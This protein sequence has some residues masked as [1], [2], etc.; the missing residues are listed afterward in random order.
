MP[1]TPVVIGIGMVGRIRTGLLGRERVGRCFSWPLERLAVPLPRVDELLAVIVPWCL[2]RDPDHV[3]RDAER[4][5][6]PR[7]SASVDRETLAPT[8]KRKLVVVVQG[9][10][11]RS[12]AQRLNALGVEQSTNHRECRDWIAVGICGSFPG[13]DRR[14]LAPV[15]LPAC[16]ALEFGEL[17]DR[18]QRLPRLEHAVVEPGDERGVELALLEVLGCPPYD[19]R[20]PA[21]KSVAVRHRGGAPRR[22]RRFGPRPGSRPG[23]MAAGTAHPSRAAARGR[24]PDQRGA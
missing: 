20:S 21:G 9:L 3:R 6:Q 1:H 2:L 11:D 12:R 16:A 19:F 4:P 7:Q 18:E 17:G 14:S 13:E 5:Q 8:A 24:R 23:R 15:P 22:G 10:D